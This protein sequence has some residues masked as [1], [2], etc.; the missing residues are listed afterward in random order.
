MKRIVINDPAVGQYIAEAN[1]IPF[2][3]EHEHS[4][5]VLDVSDIMNPKV[6]GGVLYTGFTEVA[7]FLH[8]AGVHES[9]GSKLFMWMVYDYPFNQ[10]KLE[11][12]FGVV[13][14]HNTRARFIDRRMGFKEIATIPG[15][16]AGEAGIVVC[17][18]REHCR[19]LLRPPREALMGTS[20]G[21]ERRDGEGA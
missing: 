18:E 5:G 21:E 12:L 1:G 17:L 15:L 20:N 19:W 9:F 16:F 10:L 13:R 8:M 3:P 11:R 7:C 4:I 14:E 2:R 6:L